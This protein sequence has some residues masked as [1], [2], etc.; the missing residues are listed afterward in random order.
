VLYRPYRPDDFPQLYAIERTC[1]QPPFRFAVRY[2]RKL[3][4]N[5]ASATWIAEEV[6]RMTGF[7]IVG[8]S[9]ESDQTIAYLHTL[10]VAPSQRKRGI[11]RELLRRIEDSAA[12]AGAQA[13]WLHVAEENSSAISLYQAHG[14]LAQG[15]EENYY[16]QGL[17][18]LIYGKFLEP[19]LDE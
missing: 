2:M 9:Q 16:A 4:E 11:A 8:W 12:A 10:E 19:T 6:A 18:A 15:R 5:P 14:Y 7:A 17:P 1:F 13:L 3:I